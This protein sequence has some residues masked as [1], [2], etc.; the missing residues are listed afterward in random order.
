LDPRIKEWLSNPL[1]LL[2]VGGA[3]SGLLVPYITNQ[4]QNHQKELEIKTDLVG[5][6]SETLMNMIIAVQFAE[7]SG[8]NQQ[9]QEEYNKIFRDWEIS[10]AVVG[11]QI[12]AYFPTNNLGPEW[13]K[14]SKL[15]TDVYAL[16]G[17]FVPETRIKHVEKIKGYFSNSM[18]NLDFS[19]LVN[20]TERV[21]YLSQ[22]FKLKD[23]IIKKKDILVEAILESRISL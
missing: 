4:W 10:S 20:S 5:R 19:E 15:V 14:L 2:V 7:M 22:W 6:I 3:I 17:I 23:E 21:N 16:S 18:D 13:D 11:S 12:R 8:P 9:S 1:L